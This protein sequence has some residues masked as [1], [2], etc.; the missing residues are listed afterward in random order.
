MPTRRAQPVIDVLIMNDARALGAYTLMKV[1]SA[2][3][4]THWSVGGRSLLVHEFGKEGR[5]GYEVYIPLV[6]TN[7]VSDTLTALTAYAEGR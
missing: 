3:L 1:N 6:E 5:D 2:N 7:L 4:I